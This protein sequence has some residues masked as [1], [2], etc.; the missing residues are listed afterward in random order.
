M[1]ALIRGQKQKVLEG[2]WRFTLLPGPDF[3]AV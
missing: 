2:A 3:I 1:F